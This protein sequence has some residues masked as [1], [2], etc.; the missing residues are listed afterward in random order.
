MFQPVSSYF[1]ELD[2]R[3]SRAYAAIA[4]LAFPLSISLI[5]AP[6]PIWFVFWAQGEAALAEQPPAT[7]GNGNGR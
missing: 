7:M 3:N 1:A 4:Q 2:A 6:A 5:P